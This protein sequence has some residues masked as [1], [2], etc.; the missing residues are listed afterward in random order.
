[1]LRMERE[2]WCRHVHSYGQSDWIRGVGQPFHYVSV[3][4]IVL[5]VP[6]RG[7]PPRGQVANTITH[8]ERVVERFGNFVAMSGDVGETSPKQSGRNPAGVVGNVALLYISVAVISVLE[9]I[10][11]E[12]ED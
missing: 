11:V 12:T 4:E 5:A 3:F 7:Q 6:V 9:V 8:H 2:Q 10:G 1:M